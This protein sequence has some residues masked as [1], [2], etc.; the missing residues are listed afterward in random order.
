MRKEKDKRLSHKGMV[1]LFDLLVLL[2]VDGVLLLLYRTHYLYLGAAGV[3]AQTLLSVVTVFACRIL[4]GVYRR[5]WHYADAPVYMRLILADLLALMIHYAI[6]LILPYPRLSLMRMMSL[7]AGDLLAVLSA[8]LV[9]QYLYKTRS[10]GSRLSDLLRRTVM[11]VTGIRILPLEEGSLGRR[12]NIA[13]VGAGRVGAALAEEL[14]SNPRSTYAPVCFID[15]SREKIGRYISGIQ[16]L[17]EAEI[18]EE[19]LS[20]F[21]V[22]EIVFALSDTDSEKIREL[23]ERY[24]AY[25]LRIKVYDYP[26]AGSEDRGKRS[27]RA[28]DIEELLF[29]RPEDF[30]SH[31]T[32][33]YYTDK[34]V[35]I[36]GGGG[37][38]GS[39]LCRQIARM[40]PRKLVILD[41]YENSAYD[42]QQ[43]LRM[44]YGD[45]LKTA[46]EIITVQDAEAVE[47]IFRRHQPQ[48]VLH[49]AAHKHVPLMEHNCVEA[50]KNNVFG[51]LNMV[52]AAERAG[53]EKFVM[54][55]TDKA[56]N[57]TNVMGA[58][59]RLAEIYTQSRQGQTK[60]I[61]TRFGNVLGSNG[62]VIPLFR[63][64]IAAG[65]P[66][67]VTDRRV[68][69]Y[70]MTIPEASQLVLTSG[71]MAE[72]GELFVLDMGKPV[73]I[74]DLAENMIR[75]SGFEP[76]QEIDIVETGL[77]P[78]EK[79]YEELLVQGE[80]LGRTENEKIFTEKDKPLSR[81]AI[82]EKLEILREACDSGDDE[83]VRQALH[84]TV[85]TYLSPDSVNGAVTG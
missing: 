23:Y 72:D 14:N 70:F 78:G 6:Q 32:R 64:Q 19:I 17:S 71:A 84:R 27:L 28:F 66:V 20:A 30:L 40:N 47:G 73:R 67:T 1:M 76:Y 80:T 81:E 12:T 49:A 9:Y 31:E 3:A 59:K 43:E 24:R 34:T 33:A 68:I 7:F 2:A 58:T 25:G 11:R 57:P 8:R 21:P 41:N 65:G 75:L 45:A 22:Q 29:R 50:V 44:I 82:R 10:R 46:V 4:L 62:S 63:R 37:S 52:E 85:P 16:V 83:A 79:L 53:V 60:F 56:V 55:S 48:V 35:L 42:L 74:L 15:T 51:T 18:N 13:I 77:R 39:E 54:I 36:S 26:L 61:T 69:R 5:V 38:I